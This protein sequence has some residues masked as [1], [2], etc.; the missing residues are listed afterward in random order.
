MKAN[1]VLVQR[2]ARLG[3]GMVLL[4]SPVL[5]L[6]TYPYNLLGLVLVATAFAG[7]CPLYALFGALKG[8]ADTHAKP[9]AAKA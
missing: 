1:L 3:I 2:T 7:W 4:A 9:A 5:E 8:P 6:R